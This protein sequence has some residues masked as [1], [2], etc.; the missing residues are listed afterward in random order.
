MKIK[1]IFKKS[2][3]RDIKGV[4]K[5]GQTQETIK[6]QELEEYVVTKELQQHFASFFDAYQKSIDSTTDNMGVWIDGFFGSGKS[7]FLK[8]LSYLLGNEEVSGKTA[9]DYFKDDQKIVDPFVLGQMEQATQ[10]PTDV[11]LFNIDSKA[12]SNSG[13]DRNAILNV[14]LKVFNEMQGYSTASPYIADLEHELDQKGMYQQFKNRF[15]ELTDMD[16]S[17]GVNHYRFQTANIKQALVDINYLSEENAQGY[18]NLL[19]TPYEITI[20]EFAQRVNQYI[21]SKGNDHHVVF[22]A[23][24]V[25]QFIGND[26]NRML[27][28]QTIVEELGA[29][30]QGKAWVIVTSQQAI[31]QVTDNLNGQDF[32]KIQGRFKTRISMSSANV[33]EVIKKRILQKKESS[34]QRLEELYQDNRHNINNKIDFDSGIKRPKY[35]T[36]ASFAINYPF[37]PYQFNLLQDVLNAIRLHGS[38]G[39]HLSEGERSMLATFQEAAQSYEDQE[40]GAL[41]PFSLFFEGLSQFLDHNH[42]L[43]ITRAREDKIINPQ[44]EVNPF[45]VQVLKTLFMVKY[46]DGFDATVYNLTTL[47]LNSIDTDRQELESHVQQAL[48][49]LESQNYILKNLNT[50]EFLTDAEQDVNNEIKNEEVSESEISKLLG[51]NY[52]FTDQMISQ[53]FTY[54]KL[55]GRYVFNFN[56]IIDEIPIGASNHELTIQVYSPLNIQYSGDESELRRISLSP[57]KPKIVVDLASENFEFINYLKR[58]EQISKFLRKNNVGNVDKRREQI[59]SSKGQ[60]RVQILDSVKNLIVNALEESD[61]Y[62]NGEKLDHN[63]DFANTL[64]QAQQMLVDDTYRQLSYINVAKNE[65]D[66]IH[67]F[68]SK[69]LIVDNDNAQAVRTVLDKIIEIAG[70]EGKVSLRSIISK[71][72]KIPYHYTNEDIAWII[73]KCFFN[74]DLRVEVNGDKLTLKK[75]HDAP[76]NVVGYFTKKQYLD[77]ITFQPKKE[78]PIKQI[79]AAKDFAAEILGKKYIVREESDPEKI[80]SSI[81]QEIDKTIKQLESYTKQKDFPGD[82]YLATGIKLLTKLK[83][84]ISQDS[85]YDQIASMLEQLYDWKDTMEDRGLDDFYHNQ[86]SQEI[87]HSALRDLD[88]YEPIKVAANNNSEL[89]ATVKQERELINQDNPKNSVPSL[90]LLHEKFIKLFNN[91]ADQKLDDFKQ[92]CMQQQQLLQT[93]LEQAKLDPSTHG[94]LEKR[95]ISKIQNKQTEIEEKSNNDLNIIVWG[96]EAVRNIGKSF[97]HEIEN[98]VQEYEQKNKVTVKTHENTINKKEDIYTSISL[99]ATEI[100]GSHNIEVKSDADIDNLTNKIKETLKKKLKGSN[101]IIITR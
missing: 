21:E 58:A 42:I 91:F 66:I 82:Q 96:S 60:E 76:Q 20:E 53:R 70:F 54:P 12:N 85:F 86:N 71:F 38:D 35:D 22:L 37:V 31:D 93:Q 78:I 32:S 48:K 75:A 65:K 57:E 40:V 18:I 34:E 10:I 29:K 99:L 49:D 46:V 41:I 43:T 33:D 36:P 63:K 50:Y 89:E 14:F 8:I 83:Q 7:H 62:V 95:I 77:K 98:K 27:N 44:Q 5:V 100:V 61:I 11:I 80:L 25:G 90:K 24:E 2:I 88:K 74:G 69:E 26:V 28:L 52:L 101:K 64:L 79:K 39:K 97:S 4:V 47:L 55:K 87:W 13:D 51:S 59:I 67:L 56:R 72:E 9:L 23:D 1:E 81:D 30:T 68:D 84:A 19:S 73:A 92:L 17:I 94:E 15:A 45:A 3:D 6:Q 16:W